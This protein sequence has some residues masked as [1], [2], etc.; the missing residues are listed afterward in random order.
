VP[1]DRSGSSDDEVSQ[2]E[3]I[4]DSARLQE[5]FKD[6]RANNMISQYRAHFTSRPSRESRSRQGLSLDRRGHL[7]IGDPIISP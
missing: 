6:I 1:T 3:P 5:A 4:S 2:R 7:E